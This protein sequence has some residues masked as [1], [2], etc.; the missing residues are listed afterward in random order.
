[1]F[2][3]GGVPLFTATKIK[4]GQDF[5]EGLYTV[6][7]YTKQKPTELEKL[8]EEYGEYCLQDC[9]NCEYYEE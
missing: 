4:V 5:T 8:Q 7:F 6:T 9:E 3:R 2:K 1:M